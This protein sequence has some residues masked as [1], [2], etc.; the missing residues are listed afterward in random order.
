[1]FNYRLHFYP[2]FRCDEFYFGELQVPALMERAREQLASLFVYDDGVIKGFVRVS[3]GEIH[4]LFVEPVLQGNGIGAALL[5]Y[6]VEVLG[7]RSLWA[8]EKNVRAIAFYGRH[9]FVP[10]GERKPEEDTD[11]YLIRLRLD[12][13]FDPLT[14]TE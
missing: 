14:E 6:A 2:I 5:G 7:G 13:R 9:G 8:L 4:K 12:S 1:I 3:D 11:E 10:T